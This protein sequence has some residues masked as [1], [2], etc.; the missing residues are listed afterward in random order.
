MKV[1]SHSGIEVGKLYGNTEF[2]WTV[3]VLEIIPA[4]SNPGL[5]M[6]WVINDKGEMMKI[7][8][9]RKFWEELAT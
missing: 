3:L 2:P 4:Y 7:Q 1:Q 8:M 5:P 6:C 9:V